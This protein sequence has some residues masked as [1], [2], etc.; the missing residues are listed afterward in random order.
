M[1][2]LLIFKNTYFVLKEIII[3]KYIYEALNFITFYLIFIGIQKYF[4]VE[5]LLCYT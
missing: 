4:T 3:I 2:G 1:Y 5:K